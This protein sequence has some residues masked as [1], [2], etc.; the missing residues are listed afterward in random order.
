MC[1][2]EI[3]VLIVTSMQLICCKP[4]TRYGIIIMH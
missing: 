4:V 1:E 3:Q 2:N